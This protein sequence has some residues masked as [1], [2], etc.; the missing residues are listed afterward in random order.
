LGAGSACHGAVTPTVY[1]LAVGAYNNNHTQTSGL[2]AGSACHG[3]VTPTVYK[4][5]VGAY[6]NNHIQTSGLGAGSACPEMRCRQKDSGKS[7][8]SV[9]KKC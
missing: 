6:N 2:G 7:I 3:A 5:A 1:K 8:K 9:I 4:L